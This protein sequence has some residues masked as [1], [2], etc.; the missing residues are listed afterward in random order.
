MITRKKLLKITLNVFLAILFLNGC[1]SKEDAVNWIF[2]STLTSETGAELEEL[3]QE[4]EIDINNENI[5]L[6][7]YSPIYER[8]I[9]EI[10]AH[11]GDI[12]FVEEQLLT[13]VTFDAEGLQPLNEAIEEGK[14]VSDKFKLIDPKSGEENIYGLPIEKDSFMLNLL[15]TD[16][17]EPIVAI[18]PIY[19]EKFDSSI[20]AL[21]EL[22][23]TDIDY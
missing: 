18:I 23:K 17:N 5:D 10:A 14:E 22:S 15:G 19:S 7:F 9:G 3:M 12:I 1:S 13:P 16:I 21:E 6:Q 8:L 11:H 2:F 4:N 20:K